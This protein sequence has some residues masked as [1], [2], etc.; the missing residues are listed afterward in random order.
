M[1]GA[2]GDPLTSASLPLPDGREAL[3]GSVVSLPDGIGVAWVDRASDDAS[4]ATG[5]R[6]NWSV[7]SSTDGSWSAPLDLGPADEDAD[8]PCV[9]AW[10]DPD[11]TVVVVWPSTTS[12]VARRRAADGSW[13]PPEEPPYPSDAARPVEAVD[14]DGEDPVIAPGVVAWRP[15]S[16]GALTA[17]LDPREGWGAPMPLPTEETPGEISVAATPRGAAVA[18]WTGPEPEDEA[19]VAVSAAT[20][21]EGG[22]AWTSRG[23]LGEAPAWMP[24]LAAAIGVGGEALVA[25]GTPGTGGGGAVGDVAAAW[26]TDAGPVLAAMAAPSSAARSGT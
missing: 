3:E 22:R 18:I 4:C 20:V 9:A 8:I 19:P 6:V 5:G 17:R 24:D 16:G 11:G 25:W 2:P 1:V 14:G 13:S 7:R 21:A 15:R 12:L 26:L 10:A 23:R